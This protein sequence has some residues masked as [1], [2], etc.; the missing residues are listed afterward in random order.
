[1]TLVIE[2]AATGR[3]VRNLVSE[4]HFDA[5]EQTAW[6]DGL[7]DLGRDL[8]AARHGIYAVPGALVPPGRYRVR[9]SLS[10]GDG[11]SL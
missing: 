3:R 9:G 2:E 5:G 6:W 1:M 7:D 8:D 11:F 4:T 10:L